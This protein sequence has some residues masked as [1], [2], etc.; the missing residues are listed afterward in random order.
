MYIGLIEYSCAMHGTNIVG[1]FPTH[2]ALWLLKINTYI[3]QG[4][5]TEEIQ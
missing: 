4:A 3:L 5:S 1:I 2:H